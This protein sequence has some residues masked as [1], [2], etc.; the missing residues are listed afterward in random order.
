F[1]SRAEAGI[2]A[3]V[4]HLEPLGHDVEL[5]ARRRDEN[6]GLHARNRVYAVRAT[7]RGIDEPVR[8]HV[9]YPRLGRR[10]KCERCRGD[11]DDRVL[12]AV[13]RDVLADDAPVAAEATSP[14]AIGEHDH[15]LGGLLVF[16]RGEGAAELRAHAEDVEEG[17]ADLSHRETRRLDPGA[18]EVHARAIE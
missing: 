16:A 4:L 7:V 18:G 9:W 8:E 6:A 5:I 13:E 10:W 3:R 14:E 15:T 11:S 1:R 12:V 2:A 17:R